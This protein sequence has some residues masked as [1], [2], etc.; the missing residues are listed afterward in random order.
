[1]SPPQTHIGL[2]RAVD[3]GNRIRLLS[4]NIQVAI[5]YSRYRHYLTQS[6]RHVLPFRARATNLERISQFIRPFDI[7]GLQELDVGS[8]RSNYVNQAHYLALRAGFP[9]WFTR[10]NRDLGHIARHGMALL[11]RIAPRNVL[12]HR[13]PGR[14]PGRGALTAEFGAGPEPLLVVV[15]HLALGR[16]A[17]R[18]QIDY[19][20]AEIRRR[21]HVVVMGDFNCRLED[22][23]FRHLLESTHLCAPESEHCTFPSWRPRFGLDHIL[24]TP[25]LEVE[26][27]QVFPVAHS[28]H[29]PI[30]VEVKVPPS[31]GLSE[32]ARESGQASLAV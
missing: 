27:T 16:K 24:V 10:V 1:M 22:E 30:A 21:E 6:W 17:R 13:L 25:G 19:L 14:I 32:A 28:D 7:V 4:Y 8:L 26:R 23:E 2:E 15:I 11:S 20:A 18:R 5:P 31:V 9:Y 12:S 29:L 3:A